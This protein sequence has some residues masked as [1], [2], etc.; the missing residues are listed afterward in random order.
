MLF[1]EQLAPKG[2][3]DTNYIIDI[4]PVELGMI[5]ETKVTD[6]EYDPSITMGEGDTTLTSEKINITEKAIQETQ[7]TRKGMFAVIDIIKNAIQKKELGEIT[8]FGHEVHDD[9]HIK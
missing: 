7:T 4:G 3:V 6:L 8:I 1:D 9:P 5:K 2:T